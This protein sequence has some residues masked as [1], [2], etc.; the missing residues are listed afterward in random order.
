MIIDQLVNCI[1]PFSDL[2]ELASCGLRENRQYLL[3][4][5]AVLFLTGM[6]PMPFLAPGLEAAAGSHT[7]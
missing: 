1:Q 7:C 6:M 4:S 3:R 2:P 5:E